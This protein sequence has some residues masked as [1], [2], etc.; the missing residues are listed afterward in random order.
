V[1]VSNG[2][3]ADL[4]DD[5]VVDGNDLGLLLAAW[6]T[7]AGTCPAD[8]N[9]DGAVDGNDLGILLAAWGPCGS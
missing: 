2:C 8:L 5:E 9:V 4:N 7:C 6:G 3:P 1:T